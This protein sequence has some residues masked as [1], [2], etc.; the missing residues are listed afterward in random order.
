MQN[1]IREARQRIKDDRLKR[2]LVFTTDGGG[3]SDIPENLR[4]FAAFLTLTKPSTIAQAIQRHLLELSAID[5]QDEDDFVGRDAELAQIKGLVLDPDKEITGISVSGLALLG[6]RAL[7]NQVM[8][9][10]YPSL[11]RPNRVV[12]FHIFQSCADIAIDLYGSVNELISPETISDLRQKFKSDDA[13]S[14]GRNLYSILETLAAQK[15]YVIFS[16]RGGIINHSGSLTNIASAVVKSSNKSGALRVFFVTTRKPVARARSAFPNIAFFDLNPM[17]AEAARQYIVQKSRTRHISLTANQIGQIVELGRGH[18]QNYDFILEKCKLYPPAIALGNLDDIYEVSRDRSRKLLDSIELSENGKFF[19]SVLNHYFNVPAE[20]IPALFD[21]FEDA[22]EVCNELLDKHVIVEEHGI[23]SISAPLV[24]A[25]GRDRRFDLGSE[26]TG[27]IAIKFATLL[28]EY[29]DDGVIPV[30]IIDAASIASIEAGTAGTTAT[31][32]SS[33][34]ILPSHYIYLARHA[35]NKRQYE[36]AIDYSNSAISYQA[37]LTNAAYIYACRTLGLSA[38][39]LGDDATVKSAV[40]KL[41][42]VDDVYSKAAGA[43]V[44]GFNFRLLGDFPA[45]E[46]EFHRARETLR[47]DVSLLRELALLSLLTRDYEKAI[48]YADSALIVAS[49][50]AY[51]LDILARSLAATLDR[52]SLEYDF[53]M[54]DVLKRLERASDRNN[55]SFYQLRSAEKDLALSRYPAALQSANDAVRIS[56][57]LAATYLMRAKVHLASGKIKE[58][59]EDRDAAKARTHTGKNRHRYFDAEILRLEIE[60]AI[61]AR[62]WTEATVHHKSLEQF[63]VS[64]SDTLGRIIARGINGDRTNLDASVRLWASQYK[65]Y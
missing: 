42:A 43:F 48:D 59:R 27:A 34:F 40:A 21:K 61:K 30:N 29:K 25:A 6:R 63:G 49:D 13:E 45:A 18:V 12:D 46:A 5:R 56:P 37:S 11:S 39:R 2:I 23:Y 26:R 55:Y 52:H 8:R 53:R 51:I 15:Q 58:A 41:N 47:D 32:W 3:I 35:Y 22:A 44:R 50:S 17:N 10:L 14:C 31:N 54:L 36:K 7:I 57:D 4:E 28:A 19:V 64:D 60:I 38:A 65:G 24:E 62:R 20:F 9:N 16:D 1:E 33:Q